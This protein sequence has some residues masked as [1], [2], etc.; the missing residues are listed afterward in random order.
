MGISGTEIYFGKA[1]RYM[2]VT[3]IKDMMC[4]ILQYV[5]DDKGILL[6]DVMISVLSVVHLFA[7]SFHSLLYYTNR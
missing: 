3:V 6:S 5:Q 1:E 4:N 2:T 7:L